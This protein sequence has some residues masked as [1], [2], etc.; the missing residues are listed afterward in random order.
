MTQRGS[1]LLLGGGLLKRF[2]PWVVGFA[3]ALLTVFPAVGT[4]YGADIVR[5]IV[6]EGNQRIE[7]ETVK[8][9]LVVREGDLFDSRR[10][11]RSLKSLFATGLFADVSLRQQGDTL[12]V[13]VVEN[14]IINR[15]AFEGNLRIADEDLEKEVTLRP[16]VIYTRSKVLAD[17]KRILTVYRRSGR[18]AAT[19]DPKVIQLPQ[20]RVDLVFEIGE[21]DETAIQRIRFVG[22]RYFDDGDLRE[23]IRTRESHWYMFFTTD[24]RYDPDRLTLDRELLRRQYMNEGFADFRVKSAV[25]ELTPDRKDF[26]ITFTVEEGERYKFGKIDLDVRLRD[27]DPE[28]LREV[29]EIAEGD[30]YDASVVDDTVDAL[31]ARVGDFGYA[32]VEIRP[33]VNRDREKGTID[34]TFEVSEGPRVFVER[35]DIS[36]NV[37]TVD[38]VIRREFRLVEGDAFN[39]SKLARSKQRIQNLGFFNKVKVEQVPGSA[40]DQTVVAVEVE[41]KPT[42]S[43]SFGAGFSSDAG[44]LGDISLTES[45]LL[46]RGYEGKLGLTVAQRRSNINASF[47]NPYFLDREIAA[48]FDIFKVTR[49]LQDSSSYDLDLI[50][51][52]LRGEYPITEQ[53]NQDWKYSLKRT[54]VQDVDEDAS[55]FILESEGTAWLSSITHGLTYDKRDTKFSPSDGYFV[56][57]TDEVAGFGGT[58][59]FFRN[60]VRGA[61]FYPVTDDMVMELS[62]EIGHIVGLGKDVG[63]T[64]RFFVGGDDLRGFQTGG[65][66]PRDINTKDSLGGEWKYTGTA[67]LSFPMGFPKELR[68]KGRVFTDFGSSGSLAS[69]GADIKD[70][71]SVRVSTGVGMAWF[72]PFGPIGLD[73]GIPILKESYDEEELLRVNFGTRF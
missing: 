48:G 68:V 67:Q 62:G 66:G 12:V 50:G 41:E 18:F 61:Y 57:L 72:S 53:L 4:A 9:Y 65:I 45:N 5:E 38:E 20:N 27:L 49:D 2:R 35:I 51:F 15:I 56:R 55:R 69:T 59:R 34:V 52:A 64:D 70:D 42:G 47:T 10:I 36:G 13:N 17:V 26:F 3:L 30:W 63:L 29:V 1:P 28:T 71:A 8:S 16:R 19:V 39:A 31:T 44:A 22:N 23:V 60:E 24:D 25:A 73:F 40:P 11:N 33:R 7:A 21:G 43:L 54:K 37:R 6:V 46:G 58:K 32:F 14:P